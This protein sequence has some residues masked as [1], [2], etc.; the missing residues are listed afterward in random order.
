[1]IRKGFDTILKEFRERHTALMKLKP[2]LEIVVEELPL[3]CV[4]VPQIHVK[5]DFIFDNRLVPAEFEGLRVINLITVS[6]LPPCLNPKKDKPLWQVEDPSNYIRFV[7]ENV[8]VIR[9]KLKSPAM[10][11]AEMLDA[12]TGGFEKHLIDWKKM[13]LG[14]FSY[15][16]SHN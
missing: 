1:M 4:P 3:D 7:E 13:V 15:S 14:W 8:E 2:A 16:E 11:K 6:T 12:I 10:S 9:E 5:H